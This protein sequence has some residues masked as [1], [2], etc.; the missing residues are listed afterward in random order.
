MLRR[1]QAIRD[2]CIIDDIP[3]RCVATAVTGTAMGRYLPA[4]TEHASVSGLLSIM[5]KSAYPPVSA[6]LDSMEPN[7]CHLDNVVVVSASGPIVNMGVFVRSALA[8]ESNCDGP[9]IVNR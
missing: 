7:M 1:R 4:N 8:L 5:D 3:G 6:E 2:P 9:C